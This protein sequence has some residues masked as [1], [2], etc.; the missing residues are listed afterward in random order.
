M[1]YRFVY[2]FFYLLSLLPLSILYLISDAFAFLIYYIIHYRRKIVRKNLLNSFPEKNIQE[3][4]DIEKKF[5][6]H[7]CALMVETI[8][9]LSIRKEELKNK[10]TYTNEF[11]Q[12]VNKFYK[13]KK[14]SI[15]LM[16]HLG[17][18]EWAG[19]SFN[20]N[21]NAPLFVLYHPLSNKI[22]DQLMKKIRTRFGTK[23]IPMKSAT[24]HILNNK[25]KSAVFTFI[26]DQCPSPQNAFWMQ[27][28]NQPTPVYY[29]PALIAQ[30]LKCP[31]VF[32][33]IKQKKRGYIEIDALELQY[34]HTLSDDYTIMQQ[35]M[36]LLESKI[37][38]Q[39]YLWLWSHN[40]WKHKREF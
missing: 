40:R 14:D 4:I 12:I 13:E 2:I 38:N 17:N 22:F 5:Y 10:C 39:P 29:G 36:Q 35:F 25:N 32:V 30:K 7:L 8:K 18:W 34:E 3:I 28:L 31:I 16:G 23:L 27:F 20:L 6:R 15:V 19:T 37:K 26:A 24:K 33:Y 9:L 11:Q 1:I 21:F